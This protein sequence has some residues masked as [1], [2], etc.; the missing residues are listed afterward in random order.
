MGDILFIDMKAKFINETGNRYGKLLV[1]EMTEEQPH[2]NVHW[3]CR[4][5]CGKDKAVRGDVLRT[6]KSTHC[7]C[8][9]SL[10]WGLASF[11]RLY[12]DIKT[13]AKVRGLDWEL[14]QEQFLDITSQNCSYC[15]LE[16]LQMAG[17]MA[18][19][20]GPYVYNGIDRVDNNLGYVRDNI[21]PCCWRCNRMKHTLGLQEFLEQIKRIYENTEW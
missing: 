14:D 12:Y 6:G 3:F 13:K 18:A 20:S 21:V 4:C 15:G 19:Y 5:D 10:P 9:T 17:W 1:I 11:R 8:M 2:G 16:P 7:G